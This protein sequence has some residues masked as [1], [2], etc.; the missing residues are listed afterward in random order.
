MSFQKGFRGEHEEVQ[1]TRQKPH[2]RAQS[3]IYGFVPH[4]KMRRNAVTFLDSQLSA[5][6]DFEHP[7][8]ALRRGLKSSALL[9]ELSAAKY[10]W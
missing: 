10:G 6:V 7:I 9:V 5:L 1:N 3:K 2:T 8:E 4:K